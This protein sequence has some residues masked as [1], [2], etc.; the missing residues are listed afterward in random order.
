MS[1]SAP[2]LE[3]LRRPGAMSVLLILQPHCA[4]LIASQSPTCLGQPLSTQ[5]A[6]MAP[7]TNLS[8]NS[9]IRLSNAPCA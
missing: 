4:W 8:W 6:L 5:P 1:V 7:G 3:I 9:R 2:A